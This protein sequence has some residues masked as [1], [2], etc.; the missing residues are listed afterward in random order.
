MVNE[1][2]SLSSNGTDVYEDILTQI[3]LGVVNMTV[4]SAGEEAVTDIA[5]SILEAIAAVEQSAT[6]VP[7]SVNDL[8]NQVINEV[9]GGE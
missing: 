3:A 9:L 7:G 8:V 1:V 6:S 2:V 4:T 5:N